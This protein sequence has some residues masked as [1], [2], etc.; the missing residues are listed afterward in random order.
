MAQ[1]RPLGRLHLL[2]VQRLLRALPQLAPHLLVRP[3][4]WRPF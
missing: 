3:A 2:A 1:L 4:L